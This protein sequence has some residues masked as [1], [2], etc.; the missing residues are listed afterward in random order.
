MLE[1]TTTN[2][3]R[4]GQLGAR[5]DNQERNQAVISVSNRRSILLY[6]GT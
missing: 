1:T 3:E 5:V 4:I 6:S 2:A